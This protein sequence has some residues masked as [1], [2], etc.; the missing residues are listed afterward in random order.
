MNTTILD[1]NDQSWST[2]LTD[3]QICHKCNYVFSSIDTRVGQICEHCNQIRETNVI[4]YGLGVANIID[5]MQEIYFLKAKP[6]SEI[7]NSFETN[8]HQ[9]AIVIFYST[10]VEVLLEKFLINMMN[11]M[12]LPSNVKERLLD[13]NQS[14]Q[15]KITTLFK[16]ITNYSWNNIV[17]QLNTENDMGYIKLCEFSRDVRRKRN[18]FLHKGNKYCILPDMPEQCCLN[19]SP[20][21]HLFVDLNNYFVCEKNYS[22]SFK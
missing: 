20:L 18:L 5:L 13:D 11:K 19:I 12:N 21:L 15:Q 2:L 16:T 8:N 4:F 10:L 14:F 17:K 1:V 22:G 6:I 3:W 7:D 9:L